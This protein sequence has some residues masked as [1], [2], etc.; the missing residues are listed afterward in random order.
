MTMINGNFNKCNLQTRTC[1]LEACQQG[2]S[3]DSCKKMFVNLG[4]LFFFFLI[5]ML[6]KLRKL[7]NEHF[8]G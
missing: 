6:N 7:F 3:L 1:V 2:E 5:I 4:K 8:L